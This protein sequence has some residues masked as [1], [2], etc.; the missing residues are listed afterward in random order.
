MTDYHDL[1]D[2]ISLA[3]YTILLGAGPVLITGLVVGLIVSIFKAV[4]NIQ[5]QTLAFVPKIVIVLVSLFFFI[6]FIMNHVLNF[7]REIIVSL[8]WLLG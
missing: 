4:T 6:P 1:I 7:F 2:I 5:E 8:P 3:Q